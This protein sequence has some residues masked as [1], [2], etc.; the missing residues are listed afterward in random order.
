MEGTFGDHIWWGGAGGPDWGGVVGTGGAMAG[1]QMGQG[2]GVMS[3]RWQ[4]REGMAGDRRARWQLLGVVEQKGHM[5]G[6][7]GQEADGWEPDGAGS[8]GQGGPDDQEG[9][10][11]GCMRAR[12]QLLGVVG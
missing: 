4:V 8:L 5:E 6:V 12:W 9:G 3:A 10:M 7:V 1:S 2:V 11:G